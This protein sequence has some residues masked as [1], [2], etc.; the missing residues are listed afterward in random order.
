MPVYDSHEARVF[1]LG[2][3][4]GPRPLEGREVPV[5]CRNETSFFG[6]GAA[7]KPVILYHLLRAPLGA[8]PLQDREVPVLCSL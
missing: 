5:Y 6:A 7:V 1:G 4:F 2:A 3:T 8:R